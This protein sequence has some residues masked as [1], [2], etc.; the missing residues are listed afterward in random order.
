MTPTPPHAAGNACPV[1]GE[2]VTTKARLQAVAGWERP[3]TGEYILDATLGT[4]HAECYMRLSP[5]ERDAL[6]DKLAS[7]AV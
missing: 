1:C 2:Q 6:L 4:V 5:T 7:G 3:A